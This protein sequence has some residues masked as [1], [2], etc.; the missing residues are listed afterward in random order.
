[1]HYMSDPALYRRAAAAVLDAA[2]EGLTPA[3]GRAYRLDAA[4][5]AH[6]DLEAGVT[7]GS[8]YLVP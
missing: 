6:A 3:L 7:T 1:M 2:V 8:S 4:A 5:R